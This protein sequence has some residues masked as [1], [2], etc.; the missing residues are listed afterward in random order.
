MTS[1][2]V[3]DAAFAGFRLLRDRPLVILAWAAYFLLTAAV[4][5]LLSPL[6]IMVSGAGAAFA[7]LEAVRASSDDAME[8]LAAI[9]R[10][11]PL[12]VLLIAIHLV[13]TGVVFAAAY[14]ACLQSDV[15]WRTTFH[16]GRDELDMIGLLLLNFLVWAAYS[17]VVFFVAD[18]LLL[19]GSRIGGVLAD[20]IDV[21]VI[22]GFIPAYIYPWVRLS[23]AGPMT[24]DTR[25]VVLFRSW[26][27]TQGHFWGLLAT[28]L[29]TFVMLLVTALAAFV[30]TI[31]VLTVV[32]IATG[33]SLSSV[34]QI[35]DAG[36]GPLTLGLVVYLVL[37]ALLSAILLAIFVAPTAEAYKLLARPEAPPEPA[38]VPA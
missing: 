20:V 28:Y 6:L 11:G 21:V 38:R 27:L 10:I 35:G 1:F 26:R 2:P 30:V 33:H 14:R 25:K 16:L 37:Q 5:A 22:L 23:L 15:G 4:T 18:L 24:L 12:A 29:L 8:V 17:A 13:F 3:T 36:G 31:L 19:V 34:M 7:N 9:A 32:V